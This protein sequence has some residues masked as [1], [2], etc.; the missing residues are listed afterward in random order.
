MIFPYFSFPGSELMV[1]RGEKGL[2]SV[3]LH[4]R[5]FGKETEGHPRLLTIR[6]MPEQITL[7]ASKMCPAAHRVELALTEVKAQYTR[8]ELKLGPEKPAWFAEKVN[9]TASNGCHLL[10][11]PQHQAYGGPA[12]PPDEPSPN[13]VKIAESL[14]LV[15]FVADLYPDSALLPKDPILRAK[16]RFFIGGVS[17]KLLPAWVSTIVQGESFA[18]L[19][20][21]LPADT[22]YA[23]NDDYTTAD[24]AATSFLARIEVMLQHDLGA[25]S[26]GAGTKA[27]TEIYSGARFAR[28]V[29]Y[30]GAI[31]AR[32]SFAATFD[33]V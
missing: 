21:L 29:R 27:Y 22:T 10:F 20:Y 7:Y 23:V 25:Y 24:I 13:S 17:T 1:L 26:A 31:K 16:A 2:L 8:Y 3:T 11:I 15:D 18:P 19:R 4:P 14:V 32:A 6:I 28:L 9:P 12:V 33:A 5:Y 30:W